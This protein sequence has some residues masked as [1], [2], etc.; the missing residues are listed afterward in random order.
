MILHPLPRPLRASW[1]A[2]AARLPALLV[3]LTLA[4]CSSTPVP[5]A[6]R[7]L[8]GQW[9]SKN[10][11]VII[12]ADGM[13]DYQRTKDD[14]TQ[15]SID[16]PIKKYGPGGFSAGVGPFMTDFKVN[17]RPNQIDGVWWMTF[18]GVPVHRIEEAHFVGERR[19]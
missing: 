18:E 3:V 4:A 6:D 2:R 11:T 5:D 12:T 15:V 1:L 13:L 19:D 14:G 7:D 17:E 10:L 16:A 8:V 9:V